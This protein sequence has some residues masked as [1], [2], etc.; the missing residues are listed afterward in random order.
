MDPLVV[1]SVSQLIIPLYNLLCFIWAALNTNQP[2]HLTHGG[3][4]LPS[5]SLFLMVLLGCLKS[6]DAKPSLC[7]AVDCWN[8][9]SSIRNNLGTQVYIVSLGSTC[10][11][12]CLWDNQAVDACSYHYNTEQQTKPQSMR[13]GPS[14]RS[15]VS[16]Q[17]PGIELIM[18]GLATQ[19]PLHIELSSWLMINLL[20][21]SLV[22]WL[23]ICELACVQARGQPWGLLFRCHPPDFIKWEFSFDQEQDR[24]A[25]LTGQGG[26]GVSV[27]PAKVCAIKPG[28]FIVVVI[29]IGFLCLD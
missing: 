27:P 19:V 16:V 14:G 17:V 3:F 15:Q 6:W 5:P 8:P 4:L 11:L 12:S 29:L 23:C 28:F 24:S 13:S 22:L 25:R 21:A 20:Q 18:S 2:T 26:Y 1:M 9:Y 7:P 10:G